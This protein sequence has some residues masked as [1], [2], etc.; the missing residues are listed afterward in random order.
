VSLQAQGDGTGMSAAALVG[1]LRGSGTLTVTDAEFAGFNPRTFEAVTQAVDKGLTIDAKRI[2]D[3]IG[4]ILDGGRLAVP[5]IDTTFTINGGQVRL[6]NTIAKG[7]GADLTLAGSANF[8]DGNIEA[9]V[10]LAGPP[11]EDVTVR[12]EVYVGLR[13]PAA[14]PKRS[15]DVAGLSGWLMLR[16]IERQAKQLEAIEAER[17]RE[18]IGSVPPAVLAPALGAPADAE[19]KE[20]QRPVFR[21]PRAA[22]APPAAPPAVDRAPALPPPLEIG[23]APGRR[24][25]A[26]V[27]DGSQPTPRPPGFMPPAVYSRPLPL[28]PL[29]NPQR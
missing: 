10:T 28:D 23:P 12:P 17:R 19:P 6:G 7:R 20:K 9:R 16:S 1:S 8:A 29:V 5:R 24:P 25:R 11:G 27:P 21:A 3:V 2:G 13:G 26:A 18:A 4:T 22:T 14:A 15:V